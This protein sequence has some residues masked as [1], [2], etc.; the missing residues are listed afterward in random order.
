VALRRHR[1]SP[2]HHQAG[3][4]PRAPSL[5]TTT[6]SH[7]RGCW[8]QA[9]DTHLHST[10]MDG[11]GTTGGPGQRAAGRTGSSDLTRVTRRPHWVPGRRHQTSREGRHMANPAMR[12]LDLGCKTL[13]TSVDVEVE[14]LRR[15]HHRSLERRRGPEVG[16]WGQGAT[17]R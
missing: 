10:R 13:D 14:E 6:G 17:R 3:L 11:G 8:T 9:A 16:A 7:I 4:S 2:S 15:T 1:H 5:A 12:G